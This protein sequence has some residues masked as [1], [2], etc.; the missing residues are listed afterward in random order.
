MAVP[1]FSLTLGQTDDGAE[2]PGTQ[3]RES[4]DAITHGFGAGLNGPLLIAVDLSKP[5]ENDQASLDDFNKQ[6]D[7][8]SQAVAA[9][10]APPPTQS[11]QDDAAQQ[12]QFL[13]S[14]SSDPRL[15]QVR[16]DIEKTDDVKSVSQP[17]V[18]GS[19]S[20]AIYNVIAD[21]APSSEAT[22]N[23]VKYL[24]DTELPKATKGKDMTAYVGGS[25]AGY[26]DLADQISS[27]L[28]QVIALVLILSFFLL[29]L[30]FRSLLVPLKAV[31][32]NL[33]S[34]GAAFGVVS[35]VFTHDGSAKLVGLDGAVPIVSF[36][37]LMMF[38]ILFGL[39]MDYEVFLMTH[40]RETFLETGDARVAVVE[41]LAGTARVITSAALIMV[42]VFCAFILNGDPNIKQFGVG[43]AAAVAI[44]ATIVRCVLVPGIMRL[45]GDRAWWLPGW[46]DKILPEF[47]IEGKEWFAER[48][49]ASEELDLD[50]F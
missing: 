46:L 17:Q 10:Q 31:V 45:M 21:S 16:D 2:A 3:T 28:P 18:N 42:S 11:Q 40:V 8:Q 15:Q 9:G 29:L 20:A 25:T 1:A 30:A 43:M 35:F 38:A 13:E 36:V 6:Q 22:S 33:L 47:S 49:R 26:I 12:Q 41:G 34:I 14:K 5:A 23:L 50:E 37:P 24:R 39:S 7:Q 4:Y 44:D 19:G 32:M 48:D 27:A